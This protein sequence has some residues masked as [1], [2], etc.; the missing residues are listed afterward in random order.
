VTND[1]NELHTVGVRYDMF[2]GHGIVQGAWSQQA[3]DQIFT[4]VYGKTPAQIM[5]DSLAAAT[6][7]KPATKKKKH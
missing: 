7:K 2:V 4:D 6:P 5:A 1:T 3:E